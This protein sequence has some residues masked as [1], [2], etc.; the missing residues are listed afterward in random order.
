[1]D[2]IIRY[3]T[4]N[5]TVLET[6]SRNPRTVVRHHRSEV[7]NSGESVHPVSGHVTAAVHTFAD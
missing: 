1:M 4:G 2:N 6:E 3:I 5:T 7:A